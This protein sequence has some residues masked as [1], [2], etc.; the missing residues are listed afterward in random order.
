MYRFVNVRE[1][2]V[3]RRRNYFLMKRNEERGNSRQEEEKI[4]HKV[5]LKSINKSRSQLNEWA[6][7]RET[8]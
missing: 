8:Y 7:E 5:Q 6:A 4:K 3:A 1:R 2:R